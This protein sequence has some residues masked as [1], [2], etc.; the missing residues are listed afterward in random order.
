YPP[1][2]GTGPLLEHQ[3]ANRFCDA[4]PSIPPSRSQAMT[5]R[6]EE[7]RVVVVST[8]ITN[9]LATTCPG[10]LLYYRWRR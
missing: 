3:A 6:E 2:R 1:D 7:E 8:P 4:H 9:F 5:S 10:R